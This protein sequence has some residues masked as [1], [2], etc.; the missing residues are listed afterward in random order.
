MKIESGKKVGPRKHPVL[1]Y[2]YEVYEPDR[3]SGGAIHVHVPENLYLMCIKLLKFFKISIFS[4]YKNIYKI[5]VQSSRGVNIRVSFRSFLRV[6][7]WEHYLV[8]CALRKHIKGGAHS[9][10]MPISK[11]ITPEIVLKLIYFN[12]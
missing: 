8:V 5:S 3:K 12:R 2:G 6:F 4:W 9:F 10:Q 1:R 11:Q 7:Q